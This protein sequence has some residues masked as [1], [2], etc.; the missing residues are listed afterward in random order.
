MA[1]R[2][3]NSPLI[4]LILWAIVIPQVGFATQFEPWLGNFGELEWRNSIHFQTYHHLLRGS[5]PRPY[6]SD[7][8]FLESSLSGTIYNFMLELE[9]VGA[10]TRR[11]S[12]IDQLKVTGK[13]VWDNDIAGD[14]LSLMTGLSFIQ[15]FVPSLQDPSSFHHGRS[16]TEIFVSIGKEFAYDYY[17]DLFY[18]ANWSSRIWGMLAIGTAADRGSAWHRLMVAYERRFK[19]NHEIKVF[20]N[21][22]YGLGHQ[23]FNLDHFHGYGSIRHGSIDLGFRYSYLIDFFGTASVEYSNRV[24]SRN[25]PA[26]VSQITLQVL[27]PFGL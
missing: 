14:S 10:N 26:H 25:F 6:A 16:E 7:D 27:Y 18:D 17:D 13:Y 8:L 19:E 15:S 9:A 2:K 5:H 3:G 24:Y 1:K 12:G 11:Q 4:L 23:K 22:L 21:G 20:V